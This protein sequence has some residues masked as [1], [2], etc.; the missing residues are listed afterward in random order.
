MSSYFPGAPASLYALPTEI[1]GQIFSYLIPNHEIFYLGFSY[2]PAKSKDMDEEGDRRPH[3]KSKTWPSVSGALNINRV[4]RTFDQEYTAG[5]YRRLAFVIENTTESF[6]TG[7]LFLINLRPSTATCLT[8]FLVYH[9]F[10]NVIHPTKDILDN[11]AKESTRFKL[12]RAAFCMAASAISLNHL[13]ILVLRGGLPTRQYA[14]IEASWLTPFL[15]IKGVGY[16]GMTFLDREHQEDRALFCRFLD[17]LNASGVTAEAQGYKFYPRLTDLWVASTA[18]SDQT[19]QSS[20]MRRTASWVASAT[21][22]A[23]TKGSGKTRRDAS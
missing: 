11:I 1:R 21:A 19:E 7:M 17:D 3:A 23:H 12:A 20:K 5:V 4:C 10:W 22:C 9:H 6:G 16:F 15:A 2:T 18:P 14:S 13:H 8:D